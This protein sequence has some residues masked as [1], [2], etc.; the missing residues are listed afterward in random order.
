MAWCKATICGSRRVPPP[1][2]PC[3]TSSARPAGGESKT[4]PERTELFSGRHSERGRAGMK[5]LSAGDITVDLELREAKVGNETIRLTTLEFGILAALVRNS[6]SLVT[7]DFLTNVAMGRGLG[8]FGRSVDVHISN[9]R[10][11]LDRTGALERIKTIRGNGYMLAP[12][13]AL[14][15]AGT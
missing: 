3:R 10:R 14:D 4:E 5:R 6:G 11:K 13:R 9:L 15:G 12:R 8:S 7:R 2:I 1:T